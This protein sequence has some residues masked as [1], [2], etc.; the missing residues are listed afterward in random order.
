MSKFNPNNPPQAPSISKV[1][2]NIKAKEKGRQELYKLQHPV[3]TKVRKH[4][5]NLSSNINKIANARAINR[6]VVRKSNVSVKLPNNKIENIFEDEN[7]FFKG[8]MAK[9]KKAMFLS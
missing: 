2:S 8:E 6:Q 5:S 3:E 7:R 4:L 1:V 9:E